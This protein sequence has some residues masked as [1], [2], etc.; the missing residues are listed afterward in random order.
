MKRFTTLLTTLLAICLSL[1]AAAQVWQGA[2]QSGALWLR[3]NTRT[4]SVADAAGNVYVG[5]EF[6]ANTVQPPTATATFGATVLTVPSDS[7]QGFIAKLSPAGQ[8][9]WAVPV[10]RRSKVGSDRGVSVSGLALTPAGDVVATGVFGRTLR[11]GATTLISAG[12]L[13]GYAAR[14]SGT[15][16]QWTWAERFG[17]SGQ[18]ISAGVALTPT[19]DV[20]VCGRFVSPQLSFGPLAPLMLMG[21]QGDSFVAQLDGTTRQ[22]QW[23]TSARGNWSN[24]AN[25]VAVDGSGRAVVTG[26][27]ESDALTMGTLPPLAVT[28]GS[29]GVRS[30]DVYVAQLS[31]TGQWLWS[32]SFGDQ[33]TDR[34]YTIAVTAAGEVAVGGEYNGLVVVGPSSFG[35]SGAFVAKFSAA[36]QGLWA[37]RI[38][39]ST[40]SSVNNTIRQ[41]AFDGTGQVLVAGILLSPMAFFQPNPM[42]FNGGGAFVGR[43]GATGNWQW[44]RG[45]GVDG[46]SVLPRPNGHVLVVGL[47]SSNPTVFGPISLPLIG[48]E[49]NV[50]VATLVPTSVGLAEEAAADAAGFRLTPNPAHGM[51]RVEWPAGA[52]VTPVELLDGLGRVVRIIPAGAGAPAVEVPLVGLAPGLYGVR[53]GNRARRLVVE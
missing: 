47:M 43:L 44:V 29:S 36:G 7:A 52:A 35:G 28:L 8:W 42:Q 41:V 50:F 51:V 21:G 1:P 14:L 3:N 38:W 40:G 30:N 15:S 45:G 46:H 32:R 37:A 27:F 49:Q 26:N 23:A 2:Y 34:G 33:N 12:D 6:T 5:G 10:G 18:E 39:G 13:D 48:T 31:P 16:G 20:V 17:G 9:L 22:W 4:V 24:R 19:G 11:L 53:V 25:A